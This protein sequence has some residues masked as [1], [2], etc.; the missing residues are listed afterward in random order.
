M[1]NVTDDDDRVDITNNEDVV[2]EWHGMHEI[3]RFSIKCIVTNKNTV[4]LG[5]AHKLTL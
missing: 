5:P 2:T 1:A 3:T 4:Q